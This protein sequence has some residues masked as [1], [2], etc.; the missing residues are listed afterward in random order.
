MSLKRSALLFLTISSL[1]VAE[2]TPKEKLLQPPP[3]ARHYTISSLAAKHGDVWSWKTDNGEVAYRMS[4]SLRG[5]KGVPVYPPPW[6]NI[7]K[8]SITCLSV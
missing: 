5:W 6:A 1:A 7:P 4:M 8:Y 3:T 2:P